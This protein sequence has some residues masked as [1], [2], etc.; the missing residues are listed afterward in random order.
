VIL[1]WSRTPTIER[2]MGPLAIVGACIA[3]GLDNNLTRKVSLSD[4]LQIVQYKGLV[5]GPVNVMIGLWAGSS[6]PQAP[7]LLIAMVVGFVGY[8]ISLALFV[9]AL[10]HLGSA[11]TSA[12]FSTAPFFGAL[13]AIVALGEPVTANLLVG[14]G[15]MGLGVWLH[16]TERHEHQHVHDEMAHAHPHVHDE[17]HR[18]E[19]SASDPPGEPHTHAHRHAR[20][21]HAH[22]H[23]PDMHHLHRHE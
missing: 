16:L 17:H 10:R 5:A 2:I 12:Y 7:A 19:H 14:G 4:P 8:G 9:R 20:L 6:L 3:W 1:S 13:A 18:H 21:S 15:L 22:P 11:R 23:V